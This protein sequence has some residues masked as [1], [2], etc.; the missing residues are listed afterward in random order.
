MEKYPRQRGIG[1]PNASPS[2]NVLRCAVQYRIV[3]GPP[4]PQA[5]P[6]P[7]VV[8]RLWAR[9]ERYLSFPTAV[10]KYMPAAT[11]PRRRCQLPHRS[12][13]ERPENSPVDCM[14][15]SLDALWAFQRDGAGRPVEKYP[16]SGGWGAYK[17]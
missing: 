16:R 13:I 11:C 3:Q 10:G 7:T 17:P 14:N 9:G 5:V 12:G 15:A 6:L 1:L 2:A 8:G 4:P